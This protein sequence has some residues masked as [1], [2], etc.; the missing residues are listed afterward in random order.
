M[1]PSFILQALPRAETGIES[2]PRFGFA[3]GSKALSG[4]PAGEVR[5]R[6][7][8]VLR[9]RARRR[10]KEA[11]RLLAPQYARPNYDY[12]VI[13]RS[14]A[15][16]QSFADL[17]EDFRRAFEKVHRHAHKKDGR[18]QGKRAETGSRTE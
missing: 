2:L 14:E 10:L 6:P 16:H 11:A 18:A 17:L 4:K 1:A 15:L 5:K 7:G 9:N 12:V 13:G 8:A 3:V